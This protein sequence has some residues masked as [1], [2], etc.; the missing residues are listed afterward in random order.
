[1]NA[2][3]EVDVDGIFGQMT[4]EAVKQFQKQNDLTI[5]GIAGPA[6]LAAL[7]IE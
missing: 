6:T 3:L 5:D 1:V 7:A 4:S 2:G